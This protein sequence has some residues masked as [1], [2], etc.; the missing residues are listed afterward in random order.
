MI[1]IYKYHKDQIKGNMGMIMTS[2]GPHLN[3]FPKVGFD[4]ILAMVLLLSY[5]GPSQSESCITL[6]I[7]I[8]LSSY[9]FAGNSVIGTLSTGLGCAKEKPENAITI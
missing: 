4:W 8:T 6:S 7:G 3:P 5:E 2:V 1:A 9:D